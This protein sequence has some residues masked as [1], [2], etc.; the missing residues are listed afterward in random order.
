AQQIDPR[1]WVLDGVAHSIARAGNTLYVGGDFNYVGPHTGDGV[2]IDIG[3]GVA[4]AQF[5]RVNGNIN[6]T[7]SDGAGGWYIGGASPLVGT[8]SRRNL[9]HI[10]S[11]YSVSDWNP[12]P[13]EAIGG[14]AVSA[15]RVYV[16][17]AFH[18]IAGQPR[19]RLAALDAS[20]GDALDWN[21]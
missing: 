20:T 12:D 1:L 4:L 10:D 21:P 5:P 17:G 18:N 7:V 14:V 16:V 19:E 9:A 6:A 11:D 3:S 2:P 13:D 8:A 15:G